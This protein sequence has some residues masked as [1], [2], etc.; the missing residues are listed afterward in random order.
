MKGYISS[1]VIAG[2]VLLI[3]ILLYK[4]DVI[5][6][7][8]Q[9]RRRAARV[10]CKT[11]SFQKLNTETHLRNDMREAVLRHFPWASETSFSMPS[12]VVIAVDNRNKAIAEKG[13]F[14]LGYD[15]YGS[16]KP[17]P[18]GYDFYIKY[19]PNQVGSPFYLK[20]NAIKSALY[21]CQKGVRFI[22]K[23]NDVVMK[24]YVSYAFHKYKITY[25]EE[26]YN[27]SANAGILLGRN[28]HRAKDIIYRWESGYGLAGNI[29]QDQTV[30]RSIILEAPKQFQAVPPNTLGRHVYSDVPER[31][32]VLWKE[33]LKYSALISLSRY[34]LIVIMLISA[35]KYVLI[36]MNTRVKQEETPLVAQVLLKF[37]PAST[38]TLCAACSIIEIVVRNPV[39]IGFLLGNETTPDKW[40]YHMSHQIM[41]D[42]L[43][44]IYCNGSF[45]YISN[46]AYTFEMANFLRLSAQHCAWIL[47]IL[48]ITVCIL[49]V[50]WTFLFCLAITILSKLCRSFDSCKHFSR[51]RLDIPETSRYRTA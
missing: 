47:D 41:A 13:Y 26:F 11:T 6:N 8:A 39:M 21:G 27:N 28:T 40:R 45:L 20:P 4:A 33:R 7:L 35:G 15:T 9:S 5:Q 1:H 36:R 32:L 50:Y 10:V 2:S 17:V 23:D 34:S 43:V 19:E 24:R 12:N 42:S 16:N 46:I 30:L 31:E 37:G 51:I 22:Y 38:V 49:P 25:Q 14:V 18:E 29:E 3:F 48:Y 44:R